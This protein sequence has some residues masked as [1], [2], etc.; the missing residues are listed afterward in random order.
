MKTKNTVI[1]IID[2]DYIKNISYGKK[3]EALVVSNEDNILVF[4]LKD[5]GAL[6]E[7]DYSKESF[8]EE[9]FQNLLKSL[10][11]EDRVYVRIRKSH[12]KIIEALPSQIFL[13]YE[14]E[15][16]AAAFEKIQKTVEGLE[17]VLRSKNL[18]PEAKK[19][20]N[21]ELKHANNNLKKFNRRMTKAEKLLERYGQTKPTKVKRSYRKKCNA[22]LYQQKAPLN[23]TELANIPL[24]P[25]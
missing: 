15:A 8:F 25:A 6:I 24:I 21:E 2:Q 3:D 14:F 19:E 12:G 16:S 20:A 9:K 10:V 23:M 13:T 7:I 1:P 11:E 17:E 5:A 22:L 4:R 18:T